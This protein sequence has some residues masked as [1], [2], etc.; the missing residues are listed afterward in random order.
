MGQKV[1]KMPIQSFWLLKRLLS[2]DLLQTILVL[3]L[4][5]HFRF[6][7][8]TD[9]HMDPGPQTLTKKLAHLVDLLGQLLT[10]NCVSNFSDHGPPP[11]PQ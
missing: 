1:S 6:F 5:C 7:G 3:G 2:I 8:R 9:T 11:H 10:Q 4:D